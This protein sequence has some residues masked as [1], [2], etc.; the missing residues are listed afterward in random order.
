VFAEMMAEFTRQGVR[1]MGGCCGTSPR[2][3][4]AMVQACNFTHCAKHDARQRSEEA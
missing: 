1:L 2:H 3:I 4:E